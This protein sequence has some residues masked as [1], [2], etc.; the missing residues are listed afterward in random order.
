MHHD[1]DTFK[2]K[3]GSN[4]GS[5]TLTR[6]PVASLLCLTVA[7]IVGW[8]GRRKMNSNNYSSS[9]YVRRRECIAKTHHGI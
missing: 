8:I 7:F 6:N 2:L 1:K 9:R 4:I 5:D 3:I